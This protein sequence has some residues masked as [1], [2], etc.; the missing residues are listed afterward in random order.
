MP[1][2]PRARASR[3]MSWGTVWS[4]SWP[5]G[6]GAHDVAGEGVAVALELELLVAE[7]EVHARRIDVAV[8]LS[9]AR[10]LAAIHATS[11][12]PARR[13]RAVRF[14]RGRLRRARPRG[15]RAERGHPRRRRGRRP[16]P[17]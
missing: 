16:A 8:H 6:R 13:L 10:Y 2:S 17:R 12:A 9:A 14:D 7:P 11:R 3:M 5:R 15:G 4:R 1:C